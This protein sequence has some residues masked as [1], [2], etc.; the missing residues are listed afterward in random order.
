MSEA[1]SGATSAWSRSN[2]KCRREGS[3]RRQSSVGEWDGVELKKL[4]IKKVETWCFAQIIFFEKWHL[5]FLSSLGSSGRLMPAPQA[6]KGTSVSW[7]MPGTGIS[8]SLRKHFPHKV[9]TQKSFVIGKK[10]IATELELKPEMSPKLDKSQRG[11]GLTNSNSQHFLKKLFGKPVLTR[12][13]KKRKK[14]FGTQ[15][16]PVPCD[17]QSVIPWSAV[18]TKAVLPSDLQ[19][20]SHRSDTRRAPRSTARR[21]RR[22]ASEWG[23]ELGMGRL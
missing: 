2:P 20:R 21:L 5:F 1:M 3:R 6:T 18:K 19:W 16:S 14:L 23:L 4:K 13:E 11:G 17:P 8:L 12:P 15:I 10:G 9:T 7:A 22:Y